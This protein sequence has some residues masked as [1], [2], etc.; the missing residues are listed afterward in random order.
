MQARLVFGAL[1]SALAGFLLGFD[2]VVISGAEQSIQKLGGLSP[3]VYGWAMRMALWG[4]VL[5]SLIGAWPTDRSGR[6]GKKC[7]A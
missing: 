1:T 4:T 2:T 3:G 5:G 6:K 7:Q